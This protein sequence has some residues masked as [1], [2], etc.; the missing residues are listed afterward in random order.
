[1]I[2]FYDDYGATKT[3]EAFEYLSEHT[4]K[5]WAMEYIGEWYEMITNTGSRHLCA[6]IYVGF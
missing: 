2:F 5:E 1:M 3:C 6:K 4:G